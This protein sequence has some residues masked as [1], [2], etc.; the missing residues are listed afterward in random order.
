MYAPAE[1]DEIT[2]LAGYIEQ[3]LDHLRASVYGLTEQEAKS[4]PC[5]SSL[6]V[7]A[8]VKHAAY[9]LR[10]YDARLDGIMRVLDEEGFAAYSRSL[11]VGEDEPVSDV[12]AEFDAAR[13]AFAARLAE[14]D[15]DAGI[16]E[17][18][19]PWD[20]IFDER[21]AKARFLLVHVVEEL[22]RHA[23]HADIIRE[24]IDGTAVPSLVLTLEGAEPSQFFQ[25]F[26]AQPG[27]IGG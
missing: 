20:G 16:T 8:L 26:V 14:T 19:A 11:V 27:T 21:P 9:V 15:P 7:A 12:L 17:P 1:H 6:S 22:A 24:Q 10:G 4:T 18:P 25:P 5:R 3:Q 23:G 2:G 13:V